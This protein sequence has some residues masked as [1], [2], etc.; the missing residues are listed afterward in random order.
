MQKIFLL[1]LYLWAISCAVA[2]PVARYI[3]GTS[4][5]TLDDE[6]NTLR[7]SSVN[8]ISRAVV[9]A[10]ATSEPRIDVSSPKSGGETEEHGGHAGGESGSH[11]NSARSSTLRSVSTM[12]LVVAISVVTIAL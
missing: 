1:P 8:L 12:G 10:H 3:S 4:F 5:R 6:T 11:S 2:E 7:R 9:P